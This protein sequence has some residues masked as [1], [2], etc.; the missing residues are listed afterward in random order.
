MVIPLFYVAYAPPRW[1]RRV[2]REGEQEPFREALNDLLLRSPDL[3]SLARRAAEWAARLVGA[4]GAM[5]AMDDGEVLAAHGLD[6]ATAAATVQEVVLSSGPTDSGRL[7]NIIRVP[8]GTDLGLASLMVHAGPLTPLFGEDEVARL[9]EYGSVVTSALD[10][11]ILLERLRRNSEL[12][13]LA[14]DAILTW[15]LTTDAVAYWNRSAEALYGYS[16]DE[17][18]G[19]SPGE[20]LRTELPEARELIV[21]QLQRTGTWEGEVRQVTKEGRTINVSARWAMQSDPEGRPVAVLEINRDIT[22]AKQAAADLLRARDEAQRAN[23][24]KSEYLSRMSH[25]LRT[26]LTAIL[27]YSDLLE[28]RIPRDDQREAIAAIQR[29]S[30]QLL[31]LVNDVL[32]IARIES[33]RERLA[34]ESV[35]VAAIVEESLRLVAPSAMERRINLATD[36]GDIAYAYVRAD[37]Q[38]HA[39]AGT[40]HGVPAHSLLSGKDPTC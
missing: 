22:S 3:A 5:I 12:L 19:T 11:V 14:Y 25:E 10:R 24:A 32:D 27:G 15:D 29:A 21:E 1:L 40:P 28:L 35:S 7:K 2:W 30:D 31:S 39:F 17:A 9:R 37:R 18:S 33:G 36:F 16:A 20:L 34:P 23:A 13:D 26:P 38:L 4:D 6:S 8:L